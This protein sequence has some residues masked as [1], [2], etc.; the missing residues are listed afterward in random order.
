MAKELKRL[1]T[2]Q[3]KKEFAGVRDLVVLDA[4]RLTGPEAWALRGKLAAAKVR[5]RVLRNRIAKVA[6]RES[7]LQ[8]AE[9]FLEGPSAVVWGGDGAADISRIIDAWNRKGPAVKV[10]GGL[11]EGNP[12]TPADVASW[13]KLPSRPE[14]LSQILSA[15]L[16]PATGVAGAFHASLAQIP[17]LVAAHVEKLEKE[18]PPAEAK[19]PA[20]EAAPPAPPA[21]V[22]PPA[23]EAK[24]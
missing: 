23:G 15:F 13:A 4:S 6:L 19:P 11:I 22:A 3:W 14:L 9:P 10:R 18:T 2:T 24:T 16:A 12:G 8:A 1:L 7:G 17:G 21:A 5:M 20:P